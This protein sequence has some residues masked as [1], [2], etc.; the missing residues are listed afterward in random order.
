MVKKSPTDGTAK[1][2]KVCLGHKSKIWSSGRAVRKLFIVL[3]Q[4]NF[5]KNK[6]DCNFDDYLV[7]SILKWCKNLYL[8]IFCCQFKTLLSREIKP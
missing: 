1:K 6:M 3:R 7:I 8:I 5:K 2:L 4:N